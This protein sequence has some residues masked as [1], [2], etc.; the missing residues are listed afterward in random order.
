M[1]MSSCRSPALGHHRRATSILP[2]TRSAVRGSRSFTSRMILDTSLGPP[3][4]LRVNADREHQNLVHEIARLALLSL[5][6]LDVKSR[7]SELAYLFGR[8][9]C[10]L[11][12]LSDL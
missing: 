3:P 12:C 2:R 9:I 5:L 4:T 6:Q 1:R 10:G 8:H 7:R 11:A